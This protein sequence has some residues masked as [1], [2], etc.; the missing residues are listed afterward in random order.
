MTTPRNLRMAPPSGA[1][2]RYVAVFMLGLALFFPPLLVVFD[3]P[4]LTLGIPSLFLYLYLA[5]ASVILLIAVIAQ[6]TSHAEK[7][8]P[9]SVEQDSK[10]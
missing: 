4:G 8:I 1:R 5:W 2:E 10:P 9:E 7:E 3:I 6:V